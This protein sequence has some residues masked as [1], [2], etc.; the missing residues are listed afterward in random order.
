MLQRNDFL[1]I[2][3]SGKSKVKKHVYVFWSL[4]CV[5]LFA[6][7][8]TIVHE[9]LWIVFIYKLYRPHGL[10]SPWNSPGQNTAMGSLSLLQGIF[11]TQGLNLDLP[12]VSLLFNSSTPLFN[13]SIL[14]FNVVA[15]IWECRPHFGMQMSSTFGTTTKEI[16]LNG[17]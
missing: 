10:Y 14:S 7:P 1:D 15:P 12:Q 3:T 16:R 17:E 8:W 11:P 13:L 5:W 9:I 6:P 2:L 4:S